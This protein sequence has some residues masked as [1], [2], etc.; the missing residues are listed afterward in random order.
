M[1]NIEIKRINENVKD[2]SSLA[3][4]YSKVFAGSPWFEVTRCPT[5]NNFFGT[6]TSIG[7][8]CPCGCGSV[9]EKAYPQQETADYIVS[10]ITKLNAIAFLGTLDEKIVAFSWGY[11]I[12]P[13]ELSKQ[14]WK[15]ASMQNKVVEALLPYANKNGKIFYGSETGTT[16]QGQGIGTDL[17]GN[18]VQTVKEEF[19][20]I[21]IVGRTMFDG[22][23][24]YIYVEK[25]G[26]QQLELVDSEN[27]SRGLFVLKGGK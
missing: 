21:S 18:R 27:P 13:K 22:P 14:K 16:L 9:L 7:E 3:N 15:T 4:A 12:T 6:N 23:M 10:E 5:T 8:G 24:K 17:I 19:R 1:N 20:E 25:F 2:M 26:F 11:P